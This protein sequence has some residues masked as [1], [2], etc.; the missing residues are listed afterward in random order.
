MSNY[1]NQTGARTLMTPLFPAARVCPFRA[2]RPLPDM[3]GHSPPH[4]PGGGPTACRLAPR[5]LLAGR[6]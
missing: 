4:V 1:H 5:V 6:G 2:T 3:W